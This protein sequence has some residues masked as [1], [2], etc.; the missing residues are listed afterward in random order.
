MINIEFD[1]TCVPQEQI[2][3][4]SCAVRSIVS[5]ATN[6]DD[7]F[8]YANSSQIKIA[9]APIELFIQ[10]SSAAMNNREALFAAIKS[11]LSVW[12]EESSFSHPI[13]L[14]L[15]PMDWKVETGI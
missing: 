7:V 8:V 13:N 11:G 4:L 12:K 3:N 14:T 10:M 1:D 2:Q 5:R 6:I 15:I 9:I